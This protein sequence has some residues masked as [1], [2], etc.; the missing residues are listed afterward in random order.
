MKKVIL[1]ISI[2]IYFL[3]LSFS[4]FANQKVENI[5]KDIDKNYPYLNEL[6][7]LYDNWVI[8][9]DNE[10]KFNSNE[11]LKRDEFI[12]MVMEVW[13]KKCIKPNTSV[14]YILKYSDKKPFFDVET[15]N[16]YFYC[17]ADA[18]SNS[19]TKW[20]SPSYECQ[21]KTKKD[22]ETPFC[23]KNYITLE[24]AIAFL[25]RN[26][27]TFTLKDEENI[28]FQ[29]KNWLITDELSKDVKPLNSDW[30]VYSFYWYFKKALELDY[31]EYDIYWKEKKYNLINIDNNW[32]I[33]PKKYIKKE[34]FLKIAYIIS[35]INSCFIPESISNNDNWDIWLKIDIL[36]KTCN[37][38]DKNC[39]KSDLDDKENTYDFKWDDYL[40]CKTWTPS[41]TWMIY[42]QNTK[43]TFIENWV[44]LDNYKLN[45]NWIW[46]V[47]LTIKD[48]C[49]NTTTSQT[50]VDNSNKSN[51]WVIILV[52][53]LQANNEENIS[54]DT[55]TKNCLDCKYS[56]NFWDGN[57]S[58]KKDP[59]NIFKNPWSY[60]VEVTITDKNW[61]T[62][63]SSVNILIKDI[64]NKDDS[65]N[66]N[67]TWSENKDWNQSN[68]WSDDNNWKNN[69][70]S[71]IDTDWDWVF[72]DKDKCVLIK[73]E[74]ENNWCPILE[75]K[76]L[77]NSEV[78]TC[79][80][81]FSCNTNWYCEVKKQDTKNMSYSCIIPKNWS[82]VFWNA[83]CNSCP[84][85]FD[86]DF[87][88]SIR[89]CDVIIPAIV[90]P[91]W[92]KMYGKW[93]SYQIPYDYK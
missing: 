85:E 47:R 58:N 63:K 75:T 54:F 73:W 29:I 93:N 70:L 59:S 3:S 72:D 11:L 16:D 2:F 22:W 27:S 71:K 13:C 46:T 68:N 88:A 25:L 31:S 26:S 12:W 48:N 79:K 4:V 43:E 89:K 15:T 37:I 84:C 61:N 66:K 53:K 60:K 44:Y 57:L 52:D 64:N 91:D 78:N 50:I 33:N 87:L 74:K 81:G 92:K 45:S 42:N 10:G 55:I 40:V 82:S 8:V 65:L 20:Y 62:S 1:Y 35:K 23:V 7:N 19:I 80:S 77:A 41:Y 21:D 17:I 67:N 38:D 69:D 5:F 34:D 9:P 76:C 83:M 39:K 24:E 14:D 32:N 49:W 28:S 51:L 18:T 36:N 56:W 30:S 6:Q 86:I 90:S